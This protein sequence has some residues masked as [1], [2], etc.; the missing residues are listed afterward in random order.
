MTE[1]QKPMR[2]VEGKR[3]PVW[4][5]HA[6][7]LARAFAGQLVPQDPNNESAEKLLERIRKEEPRIAR[8]TRMRTGKSNL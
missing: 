7:H 3:G 2:R 5:D 1:Q 6:S 8:I 4:A